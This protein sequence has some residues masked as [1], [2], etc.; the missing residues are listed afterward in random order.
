VS[1]QPSP[2][3]QI[4]EL[5]GTENKTEQ[6]DVVKALVKVY[7][8]PSITVTVTLERGEVVLGVNSLLEDLH[9]D[10]VKYVLQKGIDEVTKA[11]TRAEIQEKSEPQFPEGLSPDAELDEPVAVKLED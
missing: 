9:P 5:L 2:T 8:A 7:N 11:V 1:K 10:A 6:V 3:K 4:A